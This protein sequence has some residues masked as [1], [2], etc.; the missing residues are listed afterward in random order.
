MREQGLTGIYA[1]YVPR[2][3]LKRLERESR[4]LDEPSSERFAGAVLFADISGFT[5]LTEAFAAQG[6]EGAEALTRILNDYFGR[7]TTIVSAHGGD[8]LKFA[9]DALMALWQGGGQD[10]DA[11]APAEACRRALACSLEMQSQLAGYQA[12]GHPLSLRVAI[13]VGDG[14][15]LHLGG[16]FNRWEF[17]VAGVPLNQVGEV[18]E[19]AHPGEVLVSADVWSQVMG[20]AEGT[21]VGAADAETPYKVT[22]ASPLPPRPMAPME[23]LPET[24][25]SALRGYLPAAITRR[26]MAGQTDFLGELR[27][28][29]ILF[30]NLPDL[31]HDTPLELAQTA[32]RSLQRALYLPWEGSINKLSVD[33]KGISLV[34]A[35]GLPPF[36]HEDDAARGV[37]AALAMHEALAGLGQ[38]CSIGVASG[39]VYCGSMGGSGRQEYTIM[40]DKVNLAARL[41]QHADGFVLCDQPT[42]ERSD[43]Q[44]SYD[45]PRMLTVKG[46]REPLP[47]YRPRGVKQRNEVEHASEVMI[48][49][50]RES[51]ILLDALDDLIEHGQS[52]LVY[53]EGEAGV[54]KSRLIEHFV[55]E[56]AERQHTRVLQGAG[57][58]I[59]QSTAYFA[60]QKPLLGLFELHAEP[61]VVERRARIERA[62]AADAEALQLL[63]LLNGIVRLEIPE[64]ELTL[65]MSGE[66]RASNLEALI[67]SLLQFAS[68]R[69]PL[70]VIF[71]DVH[72][73]DSASW[74]L[75]RN[76]VQQVPHT[77]VVLGSRPISITE[78]PDA[79]KVLLDAPETQHVSLERMEPDECVALVA[80]RLDVASLPEAAAQ[81]IRERGE[82]HPFFSEEIGYAMRDAG[83]LKVIDG[84]AVMT[85][86]NVDQLER[87]VPDAIEGVITSRIDRL[88]PQQQLALKVASCIGRVFS[89]RLL[90]GVYPIGP[91]VAALPEELMALAKLDL[92]PLE[93]PE[94]EQAYIFKH[95]I[96]RQVAYDLMLYAQRKQLHAAIA[97]WHEQDRG[98]N[99]DGLYPLLAHHWGRAEQHEK[100]IHYLERAAE[101]ALA[102]SANAEVVEFINEAFERAKQLHEPPSPLRRARW[103]SMLG[104]AQNGLG[105]LDQ[106]RTSLETALEHAGYPAPRSNAALALAILR[107]A[108]TQVR[109]RL[110][111][112]QPAALDADGQERLELAGKTVEQLFMVYWFGNDAGRMLWS[113][114]RSTNLMERVGRV[115][116]TL[117]RGYTEISVSMQAVPLQRQVDFYGER[118]I[119]AADALGSLSDKA[120]AYVATCT[121]LAATANW[122]EAERRS[123]EAIAINRQLG[124]MRR[125]EEASGNLALIRTIYGRFDEPKDS[126]YIPVLEAARKRRIRQTEGWGLAIWSMNLQYMQ[127]FDELESTLDQLQAWFELSSEGMDDISRLEAMDLLALRGMRQGDEAETQR[128]LNEAHR[129]LESL[130][131]PSQYRNMPATYLYAEALLDRWLAATDTQERKA[132]E[133]RVRRVIRHLR[134]YSRIFPIGRPR[135][136]WVVGRYEW[137]RGRV[138][139][140]EKAWNRCLSAARELDMAYDRMLAHGA[141]ANLLA[142]GTEAG[143][144]HAEQ[145]S[146]HCRE[147]NVPG[148]TFIPPPRGAA[149]A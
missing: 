122:T 6:P 136:A 19:R 102:S 127:R 41:M 119:A 69:K 145:F 12:E 148:S 1:R 58:S 16:Q 112:P 146:Q 125:W 29:T 26:I 110:R 87:L 92:T 107:Q 137:G 70:V 113:C 95:A 103:L 45:A 38:R 115:T 4:A 76:V 86:T 121:C 85:E 74:A 72:W 84:Q 117:V 101:Q 106:A 50:E 55:A 57:D 5:P 32:F 134:V 116:G 88:S 140:A 40:G 27:R 139:Q 49:R 31:H 135:L 44:I 56:L 94:P 3:V 123:Q 71:D 129:L 37:Q 23:A 75:I 51:G 54:G 138:T 20:H 68:I 11:A 2:L 34:A 14:V 83:I 143:R 109:N 21:P 98:E 65:Q 7:L 46:K 17:A 118:A 67:V 104:T 36:A 25:E 52:S 43:A 96:T 108:G 73:M 64:T 93:T 42:A 28:L 82:G 111:P 24:L 60:W 149:A 77:L 126:L 18:G 81:L 131:R 33:D 130:G 53:V 10:G 99:L 66:V 141:L 61:S 35:L 30:V 79:L 78:A 105:R 9:G 39:R 90:A 22:A 13:G 63:P 8:V 128:W 144:S 15:V 114:L 133:K 91:D 48:G 97:S 100:A 62:L 142:P 132:R 59:E 120:W 89:I 147:L 47:V 80:R 124:D